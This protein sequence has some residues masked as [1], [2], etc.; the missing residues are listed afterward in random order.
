MLVTAV[1]L[2]LRNPSRELTAPEDEGSHRKNN[3][4]IHMQTH[5]YKLTMGWHSWWYIYIPRVGKQTT[6]AGSSQAPSWNICFFFE[7]SSHEHYWGRICDSAECIPSHSGA[8]FPG[9]ASEGT[10]PESTFL[11]CVTSHVE[12]ESELAGGIWK[13]KTCTSCREDRSI[14]RRRVLTNIER[15]LADFESNIAN[16]CGQVSK[17]LRAPPDV[18]HEL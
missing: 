16:T 4:N 11:L 6:L 12:F 7:I 14:N 18:S 1:T 5:S 17:H 15:Y 9:T 8:V 2:V 10:N 3:R 13:F